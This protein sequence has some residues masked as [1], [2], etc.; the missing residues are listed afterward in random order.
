RSFM[1]H[2]A[3][4]LSGSTSRSA[5]ST[6]T[7]A[8]T[9]P[10]EISAPEP[11]GLPSLTAPP[12]TPLTGPVGA[13]PSPGSM[14]TRGCLFRNRRHGECGSPRIKNG[15][16]APTTTVFA[17]LLR[18]GCL[19]D[20]GASVLAQCENRETADRLPLRSIDR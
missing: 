9:S 17:S 8:T 10:L 2:G 20:Q 5:T 4:P 14:C 12:A 16:R 13:L 3:P 7:A 19:L 11:G 6:P 1:P 15:T 18:R